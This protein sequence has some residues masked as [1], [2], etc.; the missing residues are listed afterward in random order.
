M[1]ESEALADLTGQISSA[2][3]SERVSMRCSAGAH[4]DLSERHG[5]QGLWLACSYSDCDGPGWHARPLGNLKDDIVDKMRS[6]EQRCQG[7]LA[8]TAGTCAGLDDLQGRLSPV[9]FKRRE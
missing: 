7:R 6:A 5:G 4:A 8:I 1:S 3:L 9:W 2:A